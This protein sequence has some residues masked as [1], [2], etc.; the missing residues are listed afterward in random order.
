MYAGEV[1]HDYNRVFDL[2]ASVFRDRWLEYDNWYIRNTITAENELR[3]V[4][5]VLAR[6][7]RESM[8]G[9]C[10]D[11]GG[12]TGWFTHKLSCELAI[13]PAVEMLRLAQLRGVNAIV[14]RAE[15]LPLRDSSIGIELMIVTLCFLQNP[16]KALREAARTLYPRGSLIICIVPR[17][18]LWGHYYMI[19]RL[20]GNPFYANAKFYTIHEVYGLLKHAGLE[21]VETLG[22]ISYSPLDPPRIEEPQSYNRRH[23]FACIRARKKEQRQN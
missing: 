9:R 15:D 18:S 23:G 7:R 11:I 1:E 13:D 17:D 14:G 4:R 16:L 19:Q 3:L 22:T 8:R 5:E 21:P 6:A 20:H 10:I 12:G 2:I